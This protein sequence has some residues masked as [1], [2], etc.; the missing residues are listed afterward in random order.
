MIEADEASEPEP[1]AAAQPI[2]QYRVI[3]IDKPTQKTQQGANELEA[4]LSVLAE[5]GWNLTA[6][7]GSQLILH[8]NLG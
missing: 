6:T 2:G 7:I 3:Y 4:R 8:R 5:Q 1:L